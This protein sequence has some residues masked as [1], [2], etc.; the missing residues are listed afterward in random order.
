M[1]TIDRSGGVNGWFGGGE[2]FFF[3]ST[4]SQATAEHTLSDVSG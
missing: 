3:S 4:A 2:Q 1:K